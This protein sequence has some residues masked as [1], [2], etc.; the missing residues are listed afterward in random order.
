ETALDFNGHAA[1]YIQYAYV[2]TNS[3]LRKM[4]ADLPP[5]QPPVHELDE[6]EVA[7]IESISNWPETIERA[8]RDLKTLEITNHAY[9]L[10]RAFNEFYN[11]CPVLKAE[12][13]VRFFR[14][15]LVAATRQAI[16]N[17]LHV[18]NIPVPDVM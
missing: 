4:D 15:R 6:K 9:E 17:S 10:A 3:L 14:V 16:A 8:A 7:L 1:P 13:A 12:P 18:L 5:S 11:T 2:R